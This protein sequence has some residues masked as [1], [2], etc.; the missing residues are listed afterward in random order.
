MLLWWLSVCGCS[1][2]MLRNLASFFRLRCCGLVKPAIID[3]TQQ[4]PP[5]RQHNLAAHSDLVWPIRRLCPDPLPGPIRGLHEGPP[6]PKA[7]SIIY[8]CC[9]RENRRLTK[10]AAALW[11]IWT[12]RGEA[13]ITHGNTFVG[14][15]KVGWGNTT[16]PHPFFKR[17]RKCVLGNFCQ[18]YLW[19]CQCLFFYMFCLYKK[20]LR[21]KCFVRIKECFLDFC[22]M[23][24]EHEFNMK[25]QP[26]E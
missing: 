14:R 9:E 10:T 21:E 16:N 23:S 26:L 2:G 13:K 20:K 5:G 6:G 7:Q 11:T 12:N 1:L 18:L 19:E 15:V 8:C 22:C 24:A 3:W 17:P 25:G 4:F